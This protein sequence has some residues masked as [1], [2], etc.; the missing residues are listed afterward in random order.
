MIGFGVSTGLEILLDV[1]LDVVGIEVDIWD[2]DEL[3]ILLKPELVE[4]GAGVGRKTIEVASSVT[5][6]PGL[7]TSTVVVSWVVVVASAG[8]SVNPPSTLM[9]A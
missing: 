2:V 1:K 3:L 6:G 8:A 4:V 7:T 5:V 9:I